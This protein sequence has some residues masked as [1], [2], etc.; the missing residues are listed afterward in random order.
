MSKHSDWVPLGDMYDY[1][2]KT[3][4]QLRDLTRAEFVANEVLR[5]ATLH[6]SRSSA[7]QRGESAS[8]HAML[9]DAATKDVPVL[10]DLL[11]KFV[12]SNPP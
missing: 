7:K 11:S 8:K 1:A 12:P 2:R 3:A 5:Y 6:L 9:W 4:L 10:I